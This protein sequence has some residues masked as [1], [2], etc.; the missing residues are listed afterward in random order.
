MLSEDEARA[1]VDEWTQGVDVPAEL[2]AQAVNPLS[3]AGD[4]Q[5]RRLLLAVLKYFEES[6]G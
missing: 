4:A 5:A 3:L 6:H 1:L 2:L